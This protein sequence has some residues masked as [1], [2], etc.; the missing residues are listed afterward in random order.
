MALPTLMIRSLTGVTLV[1]NT[2]C[3][4]RVCVRGWGCVVT[5]SGAPFCFPSGDGGGAPPTGTPPN[6]DAGQYFTGI[7]TGAQH[8]CALQ[9]NGIVKC[10][11]APVC[12]FFGSE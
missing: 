5:T 9:N 1:S 10:W 11:C 6:P 4:H 3:T 8:A 12:D 7:C 2:L